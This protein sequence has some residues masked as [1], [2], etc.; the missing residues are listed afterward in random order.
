MGT[1]AIVADRVTKYF[2]KSGRIGWRAVLAGLAPQDRFVAVDDVSLEVPRG[3]VMGILGRNGAGKSTLLRLLGGIYAPDRGVVVLSGDVAGLFE[4]GGFGNAQLTGREFALRY[5]QLF[6]VPSAQWPAV[7]EDM[8]EFSELGEYFDRRIMTYSAGMSARLYFS[9]ATAIAHEIYLIDELLSVGD[10]HFQAK[11]WA[12]MRDRLATGASGLLVTHDWSAVIKLC[13]TSKV[14]EAGR[15]VQ[16]G[17]SDV[18]VASY[19][20]LPPPR[21]DIARLGVP[22]EHAFSGVSAEDL[23][24]E[25][26]VEVHEAVTV[27][28][29]ASVEALQLGVGWEPVLLTEFETVG[30]HPGRYRVQL[31]VPALPL[32]PGEYSLNLFLSTSQDPVTGERRPLDVRSWTYGSGLLL[33][34]SGQDAA[35]V[36]PFPV[37]W[38]VVAE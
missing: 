4:M 38:E 11:S 26:E 16:S 5:L 8:H 23:A 9:A 20:D 1:S 17:R 30:E 15:V 6:G 37:Q 7:I 29:S 12:R 2:P 27:Q 32:G 14:L 19:L 34:V 21:A 18:V 22:P 25:F 28:V 13:R 3:E 31:C 36:G 35:G 10:A 24:L 33:R